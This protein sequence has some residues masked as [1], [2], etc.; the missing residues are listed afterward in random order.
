MAAHSVQRAAH[1]VSSSPG[2]EVSAAAHH[3]HLPHY[4]KQFEGSLAVGLRAL[5]EP[6]ARGRVLSGAPTPRSGPVS[7]RGSRPPSLPPNSPAGGSPLVRRNTPDPMK[8]LPGSNSGSPASPSPKRRSLPPT[9]QPAGHNR[10][11]KKLEP[12]VDHISMARQACQNDLRQWVRES[13]R[14]WKTLSV[15]CQIQCPPE[16]GF[17]QQRPTTAKKHWLE[18]STSASSARQC[19]RQCMPSTRTCLLIGTFRKRCS[20]AKRLRVQMKRRFCNLL[21]D[22]AKGPCHRR[23]KWTDHCRQSST[24]AVSM[25]QVRRCLLQLLHPHIFFSLV[26]PKCRFKMQRRHLRDY[27]LRIEASAE[28]EVC[29]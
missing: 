29:R 16:H 28:C 2:S 1:A 12:S 23:C 3:G 4:G 24:V 5:P 8:N 11:P 19:W 18:A 9:G 10:S 27:V 6:G 17:R 21:Q 22:I 15:L 25:R 20:S 26:L 7:S 13:S 14:L